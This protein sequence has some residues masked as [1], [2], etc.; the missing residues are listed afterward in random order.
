MNITTAVNGI[1]FLFAVIGAADYLLDNRFGFGA[2]FER[3]ICCC[4][5]LIIA[6]TGFM[7][8]APLLGELL[9][10]IV[11]PCFAAVGADPSA[12]AGLLLANDS[13]GAALAA[14]MAVDPAAGDFN[15]YF[16]AS[17][18]GAAVMCIIPMT[19]LSTDSTKRPAAIYGLLIGLFSVPAGC[20]LGGLAAGYSMRMLLHNLIP[21]LLLSAALFLAL[22][23]FYRWIVK[24]FQ[25]FG[26]VL[27]G[28]SLSG[29]LLTTAK[30]LLGLE[31][32]EGMT[33]FSEIIPVIGGIALVLSGVFPLL[34]AVTKAINAPLKKAALRLR[35]SELDVSGLLVSAVN[36]FPTFDM[37][38]S[39]TPRGV[40]LNTAF[41]VGANCMLGDHYAFTSQMRPALVVPVILAK[42]VSGGLALGVGIL[43]APKLLRASGGISA[44]AG[45][46]AN[47]SNDE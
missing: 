34:H 32:F 39:M 14:E 27:I 23:F 45:S 42:A 28:V 35:V 37:L 36:I 24:P 20:V 38:S 11:T 31:L 12:L 4:G 1:F 7:S 19:I 6:M 33:P 43:L 3:G 46:G 8:L 9:S 47:L 15:G 18:L 13:G 26:K 40:L 29:L 41:M 22:I 17:M 25:A 10:P 16:V 2:Q 5:K 44:P 30:E 21:A